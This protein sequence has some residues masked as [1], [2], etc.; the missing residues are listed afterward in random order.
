VIVTFADNLTTLDLRD[1]A[2]RHVNSGAELTLA[3]HHE[4]IQ[5]PYGSLVLDGDTVTDYVEKPISTPLIASAVFACSPRALERLPH[6]QAAGLV[7]LY[8]LVRAAGGRVVACR[9]SEAWV[10]VN[11]AGAVERAELLVWE[12]QA[13]FDTWAP[14]DA[15]EERVLMRCDD[16]GVVL[17]QTDSGLWTLPADP[18]LVASDATRIDSI[19]MRDGRSTPVR[20]L[21]GV[22]STGTSGTDAALE[23]HSWS[24]LSAMTLSDVARRAIA[25]LGRHVR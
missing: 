9:H 6:G 21:V 8:R 18:G 17:A 14:S 4:P 3:A 24:A 22:Q 20:Y 7:D 10:D 15:P 23:H 19:E 5:M 25:L 13:M 2:H 16:E 12:R 1:V 11:D